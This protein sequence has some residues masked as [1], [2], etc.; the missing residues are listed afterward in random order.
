MTRSVALA[1][2]AVLV[3][4]CG[5][6]RPD[7]PEYLLQTG[8]GGGASGYPA[9]PYGSQKG[10][11]V[12]DFSFPQGWLDPAAVGSDTSQFAPISFSDFYDPDGSKG[13]ELMLINT[14]AVWCGACKAEHGGSGNVKSLSEHADALGPKGLR[15]ISLLFQDA[16]GNPAK[17][18]HLVAW[19]QSFETRFPMA[20]DPDY[21]MGRYASAETAPL[22]MVVDARNM[23]VLEKFV[24]D[25]AAVIWP[26]I[27]AELEKRAAK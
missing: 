15:I 22:N 14:A 2:L 12:E 26:F 24:G 16:Q 10:D 21:Q 1:A 11:R 25:Q 7:I 20:L 8:T 4:G 6:N 23:T 3:L 5:T 17:P 27:E 18:E 9:G 13:I 19:T